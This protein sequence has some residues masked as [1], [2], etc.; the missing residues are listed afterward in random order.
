MKFNLQKRRAHRTDNS[1]HKSHALGTAS[2]PDTLLFLSPILNQGDSESCTAYSSVAVRYNEVNQTLDPVAFW[3]QE[4]AFAD[5]D[6]SSGF[7]LEVP[8]D[9]AVEKGFP[10]YNPSAPFWITPNNGM[11]LMDSVCSAMQT[12]N[13]PCEGGLTWMTEYT[14]AP[15]Y[16]IS[17]VGHTV[18]GGH[19]IKIAGWT[20]LNGVK[21]IVLQNSWGTGYGNQGLFYMTR[22]VFNQVF[23]PFG[24]FIWSDTPDT[25][26]K[27]LGLIRAIAYNVINLMQSL[28][29]KNANPT[30]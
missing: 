2:L 10:D 15:G 29:Y 23:A 7:D 24:I 21:V 13:R 28:I 27:T 16:L 8:A 11:D 9:T 1:F 26:I 4:L 20:I 18:Q 12:L 3:N 30:Q 5:S 25:Q 14:N 6:G 17:Q 19:D 22:S